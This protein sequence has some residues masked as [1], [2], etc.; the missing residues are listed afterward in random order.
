MN[1]LVK[2]GIQAGLFIGGFWVIGAGIASAQTTSSNATGDGL[3]IA[4]TLPVNVSGNSVSILGTSLTPAP[5][6]TSATT[7]TSAGNGADVAAA[8]PITV[9]G[10]SISILGSSSSPASSG[11]G[12]GA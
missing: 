5:S 8:A 7:A 1:H 4:V 9:S 2:R 12:S 3:P 6:G 10:N 11:A